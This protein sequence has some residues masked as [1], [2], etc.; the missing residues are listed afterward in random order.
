MKEWYSEDL[1]EPI[2]KEFRN[3]FCFSFFA[4][5]RHDQKFTLILCIAQI[6]IRNQST[7]CLLIST[8]IQ[9]IYIDS[10]LQDFLSTENRKNEHYNKSIYAVQASATQKNKK[11]EHI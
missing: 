9:I 5:G 11:L 1:A 10:D 4:I 7:D 6:I 2:P 3:N 8:Q